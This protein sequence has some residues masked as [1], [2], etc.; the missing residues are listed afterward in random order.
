MW[1]K[2]GALVIVETPKQYSLLRVSDL[3]ELFL[4]LELALASLFNRRSLQSRAIYFSHIPIKRS[5][6]ENK[7]TLSSLVG[8]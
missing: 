8:T 3:L 2:K 1:A 7:R 4:F 6:P 5:C